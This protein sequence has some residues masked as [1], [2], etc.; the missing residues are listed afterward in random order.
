[1][2]KLK[3]RTFKSRS[4]LPPNIK[5][6]PVRSGPRRKWTD[7]AMEKAIKSIESEGVSLREAAEMYEIPRSTLYDHVRGQ[8]EHGALPGPNL[9][10]TGEEEEESVANNIIGSA[11]IGYPHTRYQIIAIV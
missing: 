5:Q 8:V 1:M 10:L 2:V 11:N 4:T 6:F 9:Y 7:E 3:Q